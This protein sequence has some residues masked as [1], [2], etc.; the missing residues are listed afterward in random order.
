MTPAEEDTPEG[1]VP[2]AAACALEAL[3][4]VPAAVIRHVDWASRFGSTGARPA[5]TAA[6]ACC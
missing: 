2:G 1:D 4:G 3:A 5:P 6:V